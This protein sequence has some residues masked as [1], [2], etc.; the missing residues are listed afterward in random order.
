MNFSVLMSLYNKELPTN[1]DSSLASVW[2]SQILKPSEIVLVIDGE[3]N[4]RLKS[5]VDKWK[6]KL[7]E[8]LVLVPIK[9]NIGLAKALNLG[10]LSCKYDLIARMDTDDISI[11]DRFQTQIPFMVSNPDISASGMYIIEFDDIDN[12]ETEI[13]L[14]LSHNELYQ[15]CKLRSPLCHPVVVFRKS[16]ILKVGGYPEFRLGQDFAMWS[17][18]L[19][20]NY[21]ISNLPHFGLKLRADNDF[22]KRRGF[23]SFK[24]EVKVIKFQ[25]EIG[26]INWFEMLVSISS[27]LV[28]RTVPVFLKKIIY[29]K[30]R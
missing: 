23:E 9:E 13:K 19:T 24:S 4:D 18:L 22:Y 27:R 17:R 10:L 20:C 21:K 5:I 1:L 15:Y 29:K 3:I 6:L 30:A 12:T 25:K 26:L 11:D 14:P 8:K 28:I 16:I 7:D 2:D